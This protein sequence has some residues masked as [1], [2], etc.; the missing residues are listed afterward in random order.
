MKRMLLCLVL[1]LWGHNLFAQ[2]VV[3]VLLK[4][5]SCAPCKELEKV[6]ST[7]TIQSTIA[8]NKVLFK[9][10]DGEEWPKYLAKH[11]VTSFPTMLK[12][13]RNE[14]GEWVEKGRVVGVKK[15][16]FL[17]DFLGKRGIIKKTIEMPRRIIMGGS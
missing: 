7:P 1:W 2:D 4:I 13:E 9:A 5:K 12:F 10:Y 3:V 11:N 15:L 14:R 8:Q 16:D 17:L 6:I